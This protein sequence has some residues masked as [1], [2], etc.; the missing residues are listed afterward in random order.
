MNQIEACLP[1]LQLL[2]IETGDDL[3]LFAIN[4]HV[5]QLMPECH[6]TRDSFLSVQ[7]GVLRL[8]H[9]GLSRLLQTREGE[10]IPAGTAF[11]LNVFADCRAQLIMPATAELVYS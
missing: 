9:E 6:C 3:K 1:L 8:E 11:R 5:G 4:G 2:P 10:F 7:Q